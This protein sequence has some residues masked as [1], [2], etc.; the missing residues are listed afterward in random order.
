MLRLNLARQLLP[1]LVEEIAGR[2]H[3]QAAGQRQNHRNPHSPPMDDSRR[4]ST[5]FYKYGL[6]FSSNRFLT[7]AALI[8]AAR[9]RKRFPD[10]LAH[11]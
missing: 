6:V 4:L 11:F 8:G 3:P 1:A 5:L 9:V 7:V 10:K 2:R